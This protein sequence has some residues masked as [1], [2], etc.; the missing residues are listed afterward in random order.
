MSTYQEVLQEQIAAEHS[1]AQT[2]RIVRWIGHDAERLAAL[3]DIFLGSDYRLTQRS[4]W[5]L[6]Y[7]GEH[8]PVLLEPWHEH[9]IASMS[10]I[11]V[12]GAVK[13]NVLRMYECI[14]IPPR[15]YDALAEVGFSCLADAQEDVAVR[16]QFWKKYAKRCLI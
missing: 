15:L 9:M 12:H 10:R 16:C 11:L 1:K 6:R 14:E 3:M 7:V 8:S 2:M 5:V 4:A 13:R